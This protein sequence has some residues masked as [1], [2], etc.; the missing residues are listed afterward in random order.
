[1]NPST[2]AMRLR[3]ATNAHDLD[4]IVACFSPDYLNVTPCHPARGFVGNDQVRRN[5]TAILD[6][7]PDVAA[8]IVAA[9]TDGDTEWT[10]WEMCGTRR[11]GVPHLMRG[12]MVFTV[13]GE[14]ATRCRF[15]IEPVDDRA[16]DA[17]GGVAAAVGVQPR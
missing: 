10:E 7:V 11:D 13:D 2:F 9:T 15:F 17:D 5:W 16:I 8:E 1:M 6:G 12:V 14:V 4:Q 3:D